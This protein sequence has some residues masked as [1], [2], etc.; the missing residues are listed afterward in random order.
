MKLLA[1]TAKK[2]KKSRAPF[3]DDVLFSHVRDDYGT[4]Q[5]F[6]DELNAEFQFMW[7]FAADKHTCK[8]P[9][10]YGPDHKNP[11]YRNALTQSWLQQT[12]GGIP[13]FLNPP[14]TKIY[15]FLKKAMQEAKLGQVTVALIPTRTDTKYWHEF[16]WDR[17]K[18][19]P[20]PGVEIRFPKGR[21]KFTL[22]VTTEMRQGILDELNRVPSPPND[23]NIV[24]K[25]VSKTLKIP[26]Q[27]VRA[28]Y[29]DEPEVVTSA[30]FPSTIVVFR[31]PPTRKLI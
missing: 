29:N 5:K 1:K 10:Y 6:Y 25:A 4:P 23:I 14:Y 28:I 31:Q 17:K 11:K 9:G 18:H 16:V 2:K 15:V 24:T 12:G 20:R 26:L 7:D 27:I 3:A 13:G 30:P 22:H 21:L 8:T 19:K